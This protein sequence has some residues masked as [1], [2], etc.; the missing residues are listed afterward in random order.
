M[1][2]RSSLGGV[3]EPDS[4]SDYTLRFV[5]D[6]MIRTSMQ[7][8]RDSHTQDTSTFGRVGI[9]FGALFNAYERNSTVI[10]RELWGED[11]KRVVLRERK[12]SR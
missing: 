12:R 11:E 9:G 6:V 2:A 8:Y 5:V 4:R 10:S 1:R 7:C 3:N